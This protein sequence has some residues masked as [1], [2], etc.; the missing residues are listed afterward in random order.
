MTIGPRPTAGEQHIT[1][2]G[3]KSAC[4]KAHAYISAI[5]CHQPIWVS[6]PAKK[7]TCIDGPI[8]LRI[9]FPP[10]GKWSIKTARE[11]L[12]ELIDAIRHEQIDP[13]VFLSTQP[14]QYE[15]ENGYKSPATSNHVLFDLL[16]EFGV[17]V[18]VCV[19][20]NAASTMI[21]D[22]YI[23]GG[24]IVSTSNQLFQYNVDIRVYGAMELTDSVLTFS[25]H[26]MHQLKT[27]LP[28]MRELKM[29]MPPPRYSRKYTPFPEHEY[30]GTAPS[31]RRDLPNSVITIE[32]LRR[33]L[34]EKLYGQDA[35]IVEKIPFWN[36]KEPTLSVKRV[37]SAGLGKWKLQANSSEDVYRQLFTPSGDHR[38]DTCCRLLVA[39]V[40]AAYNEL[41]FLNEAMQI[42]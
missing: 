11:T 9:L 3:T 25:E 14:W 5:V 22:A 42:M 41:P 37:T 20:D 23:C 6:M 16:T 2:T 27:Y 40:W 13:I 8:L 12:A 10:Q 21:S 19:T 1:I 39:E 38:Y 34:Y 33:V 15:L 17:D 36:E 31:A 4:E 29:V 18:R 24:C 35:N 26:R 32:P 7:Y 30:N 28:P